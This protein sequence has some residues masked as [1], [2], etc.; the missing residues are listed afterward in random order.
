MERNLILAIAL[1]IGILVLWNTVINPAPEAP[2]EDPNAQTMQQPDK[3]APDAKTPDSPAKTEEDPSLPSLGQ[4]GTSTLPMLKK[5]AEPKP[6]PAPSPVPVDGQTEEEGATL[7]QAEA[8]PPQ[9]DQEPAPSP[10]PAEPGEQAQPEETA[11][12]EVKPEPK[13]IEKV[14]NVI[15]TEEFRAV[16]TNEGAALKSLVLKNKKYTRPNPQTGKEEPIDIVTVSDPK[17]LPFRIGFDLANFTFAQDK[18]LWEVER[19]EANKLVYR[20]VTE[21]G[22]EIRKTFSNEKSYLFDLTLSVHNPTEGVAGFSPVVYLNG[23]QSDATLQKT[24]FFGGEAINQQI[25]AAYVDEKHWS[26]M[27]R[28]NLAETV[29]HKGQISWAGIDERYFVTLL[30]PPAEKRS[31]LDVMDKSKTETVNGEDNT[32]HWLYM[33]HKGE[34]ERVKSGDTLSMVYRAYIGPKEY[35]TMK[36]LGHDLSESIDF[37][38]M[39]IIAIPMLYILKYSYEV[40]PNW[41]VAIILLTLLVKLITLPLTKKSFESMQKMRQIQPLMESLKK[42]HG[43]DKA[44]LNQEMMN[45][46]KTH[47]VNPLGGCLPMVLQMP[48]FIALYQMLKNAVELYNAPFIPGW[49]NNLVLPDP[50]YIMPVLLAVLIFAQQSLT[51]MGDNEQ[52]KIMKWMMPIMM[53]FFMIMLP[54]GLVLYIAFNT[55]LSVAQQWWINKKADSAPII[56]K[57]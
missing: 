1:S 15:E 28:D 10:V 41:G 6:T 18:Q 19:V 42:K 8:L 38:H 33:I 27:S 29:T 24:G 52:Q 48:I 14:D 54:A 53:L 30:I 43:D 2:L 44:A 57:A 51:P 36:S 40:I 56:G 13:V 7:A 37:W 32:R 20:F 26:E 25:P 16:F 22:L 35:M 47:G 31:Q 21:E 50:Y 12:A 34:E 23:Y 49:I 55:V 4:K 39:G 45:L 9:G 11:Q 5:K 17:T 46:Y 3:Q